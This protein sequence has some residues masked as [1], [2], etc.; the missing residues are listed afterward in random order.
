MV[1]ALAVTS[2][3]TSEDNY[4]RAY[5]KTIAARQA[6]EA[7]NESI[8]GSDRRML[9][10]TAV[11]AGN[12]TVPVSIKQ[13]SVVVRDGETKPEM[14]AYN[15]VAGQFKQQFNAFSLRDRLIDAGY[16]DAFVVET[17]EPYYYIIVQTSG[18]VRSASDALEK[19]KQK[20]PV[21]MKDP[22]PFILHDPRKK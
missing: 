7:D 16:K 3:K 1:V 12:D 17:A 5:E 9:P 8:Y 14:S 4:R 18:D 21:A 20:P 11:I 10:T 19:L 22:L 6:D 15:V 2:C 13:V